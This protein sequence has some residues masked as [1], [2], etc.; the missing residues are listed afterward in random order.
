MKDNMNL[1]AELSVQDKL[2]LFEKSIIRDPLKR[3]PDQKANSSYG[4]D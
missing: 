3:E 4:S 2:N 1:S